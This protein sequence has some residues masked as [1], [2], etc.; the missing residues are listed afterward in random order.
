MRSGPV[1]ALKARFRPNID[2]CFRFNTTLSHNHPQPLLLLGASCLKKPF[3]THPGSTCSRSV[4]S[5]FVV[6]LDCTSEKG[7]DTRFRRLETRHA[8]SRPS[9]MS[10]PNCPTFWCLRLPSARLDHLA[11]R[12]TKISCFP[13]STRFEYFRFP[14][15]R[16]SL[17]LLRVS[18]TLLFRPFSSHN[19]LSSSYCACLCVHVIDAHLIELWLLSIIHSLC[20]VRPSI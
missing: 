15:V 10:R 13:N 19:I 7:L 16:D 8:C 3:G 5:I 20:L 9:A 2:Y 12:K 18:S 17:T 4:K 11:N 1:L 14:G 6:C